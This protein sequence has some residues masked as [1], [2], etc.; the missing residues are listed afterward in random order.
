MAQE[1]QTMVSGAEHLVRTLERLGV[2]HAFNI[3]GLG[4]FPL[5]EALYG[6]RDRI[7]YVSALNET[8]LALIANGYARAQRSAAFV[9]VYHAS[10]TA[11][12]MMAVTTAWAEQVPLVYTTTTSSRDLAGRDQYAA[13]PRAATEMSG[14]FVKW[15]CEV[16]NASR[17]P[18][19][20]ARAFQIANTPPFGPVHVAIPMDVWKEEINDCSDAIRPLQLF[21]NACAEPD[22]LD[23]LESMLR[24]ADRPLVVAG[25]EVSRYG[26]FDALVE[27]ADA[28]GV[29]VASEDKVSDLG[30]PTTHPQ[31]VGK[32]GAD[33]DLVRSSDAAILW[34][35]ELTESGLTEPVNFAGTTMAVVS[36]DPLALTRQLRAAVA[37]LGAA[38]PT[39]EALAARFREN[40]LAESVRRARRE[41]A[42]DRHRGRAVRAEAIR[43]IR[44]DAPE[45]AIGRIVTEIVEAMP[46]DAVIVNHCASGEPFVEELVAAA[47]PR[48]FYG[49]SS[50]ASAQ[51]WGGPAAI[52]I[53]LA[54]PGRR[55][56]AILGDGGFMFSSTAVYA[57]AQLQTPVVFVVLN[58][59]G[60]RD[61][62]ALARVAGSP[63]IDAERE[64]GWEFS[65]PGIA[66]ADFATSFGLDACRVHTALELRA[67][68]ERAARVDGPSLIEVMNS[69]DDADEFSRVFT[70]SPAPRDWGSQ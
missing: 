22:A 19:I 25:S 20:L 44:F 24:T 11:L 61:I 31:F 47:D 40:P 60:W 38:G 10:G 4:L 43:R 51:G 28:T 59:G 18:E 29:A 9:N 70:Q 8:N 66:H 7:R 56:V 34:G 49:I 2:D 37:V 39:L 41:D 3:V 32:L 13:V 53:Q 17:I 45:L 48:G 26:G 21:G 52:G 63:L 35:V 55:V 68:L 16:P 62:A 15:S 30:F 5:A 67:A 14:Q 27:L 36:A 57:A 46:S 1:Q 65:E 58:N 23:A 6:H 50:K 64:F 54:S 12:G 33:R 42:Q 69:R